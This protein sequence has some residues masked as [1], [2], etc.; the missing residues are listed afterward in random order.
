MCEI[1]NAVYQ[2]TLLNQQVACLAHPYLHTEFICD[3]DP[4]SALSGQPSL[5]EQA[6]CNLNLNLVSSQRQLHYSQNYLSAQHSEAH[7]GHADT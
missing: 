1:P 2:A 5:L 3:A 6:G 7:A 4:S